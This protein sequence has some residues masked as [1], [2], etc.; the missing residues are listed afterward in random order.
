LGTSQHHALVK[1]RVIT[2]GNMEG[3]LAT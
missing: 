3:Q 1:I 2:L